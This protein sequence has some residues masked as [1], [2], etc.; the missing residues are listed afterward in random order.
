MLP[1]AT[2]IVAAILWFDP[3][4]RAD[5]AQ[6]LSPYPPQIM[7]EHQLTV[8]VPNLAALLKAA[9]FKGVVQFR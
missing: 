2:S 6:V 9:T 1:G 8:C 4:R 3:A 7:G 5:P